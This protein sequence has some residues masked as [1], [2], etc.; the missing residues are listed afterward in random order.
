MNIGEIIYH[1]KEEYYNHFK[2]MP[3]VVVLHPETFKNAIASIRGGN[4]E[5]LHFGQYNTIHG[6]QVVESD[7]LRSDDVYVGG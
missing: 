6:L 3:K 1:K 7:Q 5:E 4:Y 2:K